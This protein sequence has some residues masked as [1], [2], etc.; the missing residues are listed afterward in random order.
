MMTSHQQ[1][2]NTANMVA[3][4]NAGRRTHKTAT[5]VVVIRRC[6]MLNCQVRVSPEEGFSGRQILFSSQRIMM[7]AFPVLLVKPNHSAAFDRLESTRFHLV[8]SYVVID[9]FQE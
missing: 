2:N 5:A 6:R 7:C 3:I 4:P 1:P 9:Y 8:A